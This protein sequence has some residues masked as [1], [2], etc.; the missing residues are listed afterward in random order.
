VILASF[1]RAYP[2]CERRNSL[3]WAGGPSP[4][5]ANAVIF[6]PEEFLASQHESFASYWEQEKARPTAEGAVAAYC[7]AIVC[8]PLVDGNGRLARFLMY[9]LCLGAGMSR[10]AALLCVAAF[11]RRIGGR[12][13]QL[14][15][16]RNF[17]HL[18]LEFVA[19][20]ELVLAAG[21]LI[22]GRSGEHVCVSDILDELE[23][24]KEK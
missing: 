10:L 11:C 24:K 20:R 6:C 17:E 22:C 4:V 8:H 15:L 9:L 7:W 2:D 3:A 18:T 5:D 13:A 12:P 21:E 23:Y 1:Q 14:L 16:D 19:C